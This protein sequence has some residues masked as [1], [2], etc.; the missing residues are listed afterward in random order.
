MQI[1][2]WRFPVADTVSAGGEAMRN[3]KA[4][5]VA[6]PIRMAMKTAAAGNLFGAPVSAYART[7]GTCRPRGVVCNTEGPRARTLLWVYPRRI[8]N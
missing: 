7:L 5:I 4:E 6:R 8:R 3:R 1:E 2:R